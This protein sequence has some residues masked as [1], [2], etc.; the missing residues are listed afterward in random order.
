MGMVPHVRGAQDKLLIDC[1]Y[2]ATPQA[3]RCPAKKSFPLK[4]SHRYEISKATRA[5]FAIEREA[6]LESITCSVTLAD[7]RPELF[8]QL[9]ARLAL[10]V[11]A[12][13]LFDT[14]GSANAAVALLRGPWRWRVRKGDRWAMCIPIMI[15]PAWRQNPSSVL[16]IDRAVLADEI[17]FEFETIDVAATLEFSVTH[18]WLYDEVQWPRRLAQPWALIHSSREHAERG[19]FAIRLRFPTRAQALALLLLFDQDVD[20]DHVELFGAG[21][22]AGAAPLCWSYAEAK[23]AWCA[24]HPAGEM[25]LRP[26]FALPLGQL[27][28]NDALPLADAHLTLRGLRASVSLEIVCC[29]QQE[30]LLG[31]GLIALT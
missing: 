6:L 27:C 30:F 18:C 8:E 4:F 1:G 3:Q 25:P 19:D 10:R 2:G 28:W 23:Q 16:P 14:T 7:A 29:A 20:F 22:G 21:A 31:E 15:S 9:F 5:S 17:R 11:G 13:V 26:W 12:T 24:V